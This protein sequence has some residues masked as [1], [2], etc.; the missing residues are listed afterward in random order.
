MRLTLVVRKSIFTS[1]IYHIIISHSTALYMHV[2][3]SRIRCN[4]IFYRNSI[5]LVFVDI[6]HIIILHLDNYL[7][8]HTPTIISRHCFQGEYIFH[9]MTFGHKEFQLCVFP[10]PKQLRIKFKHYCLNDVTATSLIFL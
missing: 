2:L 9:V 3:A 4:T 8:K 5:F 6:K 1:I 10:H 7:D